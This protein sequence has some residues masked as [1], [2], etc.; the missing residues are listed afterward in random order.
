MSDLVDSLSACEDAEIALELEELVNAVN[1]LEDNLIRQYESDGDDNADDDDSLDRRIYEASQ[2]NNSIL[3]GTPGNIMSAKSDF[4]E[5]E[6]QEQSSDDGDDDDAS[7]SNNVSD[8]SI[9]FSP[10]RTMDLLLYL[11]HRSTAA[12]SNS[13]E[14]AEEEWENDDDNGY[15]IVA[16]SEEEFVEYDE[17]RTSIFAF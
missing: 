10:K 1:D 11:Q 8:Q 14:Y 4:S 15:V 12:S 5:Q 3:S 16:V 2:S 9:P 17:V 13:E 7:D 6:R